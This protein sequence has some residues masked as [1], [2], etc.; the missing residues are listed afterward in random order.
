[1]EKGREHERGQTALEYILI[2]AGVI[3]I[4]L[5]VILIVRGQ[6]IGPSQ[7]SS[8]N[9]LNTIGPIRR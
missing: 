2:I 7:N 8:A 9:A 1:M 4:V 3:V 6:I 5:V